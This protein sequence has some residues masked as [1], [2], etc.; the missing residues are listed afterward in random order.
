MGI[1]CKTL[2]AVSDILN[3]KITTNQI[4]EIRIEG[5]WGENILI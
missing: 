3:G 2:P 4:R 5:V 1:S